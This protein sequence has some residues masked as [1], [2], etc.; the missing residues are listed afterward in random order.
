[1]VERHHLTVYGATGFTARKILQ[2]FL[3][4]SPTRWPPGFKWSIAGRNRSALET[5]RAGFQ[6]ENANAIPLPDII[7]ADIHNRGSLRDMALRTQRALIPRSLIV[8]DC[9]YS[10]QYY[11]IVS[12]P[13]VTTVNLWSNPASTPTPTMSTYVAR[14]TTILWFPI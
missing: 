14:P 2:E 11:S 4:G 13:T 1:M 7:V 6:Q 5:L 10:S 8:C 12:V 9:N 3:Q